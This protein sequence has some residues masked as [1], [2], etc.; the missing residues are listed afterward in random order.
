MYKEV[1]EIVDVSKV[2][3][4]VVGNKNDLYDNEQVP[5]KEAVE[6]TKSINATYRCVSALKTDGGI[7][8]LFEPLGNNLMTNKIN[9]P[10]K[11]EDNKNILV[12][13]LT[14]EKSKK[15]NKKKKCC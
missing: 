14:G 10:S 7:N 4:F 15:D 13:T 6:Y 9:D 5:K 3:I 12:L 1:K 11:D 2:H 8:E